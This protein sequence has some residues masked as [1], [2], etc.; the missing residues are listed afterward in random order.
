MSFR[1][2]KDFD[3]IVVGA[4]HAGIEAA[5]AASR[6]GCEVLMLTTNVDTIGQMSCNPAIGGIGK[7]HLVKE[8]DALFDA[9]DPDRSGKMEFKEL[10]QMLKPHRGPK[11]GAASAVNTAVNVSAAAAAFKKKGAGAADPDD[12]DVE[13]SNSSGRAKAKKVTERLAWSREEDD[14][15]VRS[16]QQVTMMDAHPSSPALSA[17]HHASSHLRAAMFVHLHRMRP[18]TPRHTTRRMHLRHPRAC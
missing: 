8:I 6:M 14:L 18:A 16:V 9:N 13:G 15:I 1:Y 10:K 17:D 2:P 7:G 4:G 3:V 11:G 12:L 5:L